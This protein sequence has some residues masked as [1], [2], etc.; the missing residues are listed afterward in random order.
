MIKQ[1]DRVFHVYNGKMR[2]K[3]VALR[4]VAIKT[5]STG[6][7]MSKSLVAVIALNGD[8]EHLFEAPVGDLMREA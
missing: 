5:N 2:G 7:A 4:E 8:E 6:G 1:G 3:V